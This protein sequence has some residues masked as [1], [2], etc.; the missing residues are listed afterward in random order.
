MNE[1]VNISTTYG[2]YTYLLLC[3]PL[4]FQVADC[5]QC[6]PIGRFTITRDTSIFQK[7]NQNASKTMNVWYNFHQKRLI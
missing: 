7:T 5:C 1:I 3:M 2:L 4:V 6:E